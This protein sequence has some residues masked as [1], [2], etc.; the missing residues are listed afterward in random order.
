MTLNKKLV[1]FL[2]STK[3]SIYLKQFLFFD[4]RIMIASF[5]LK[6]TLGFL[7]ECRVC[8]IEKMNFGH[9]LLPTLFVS[10]IILK[11]WPLSHDPL[12][13][14]FKHFIDFVLKPV[15]KGGDEAFQLSKKVCVLEVNFDCNKEK[16]RFFFVLVL[17]V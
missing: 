8:D 14:I 13:V 4:V 10:H 9:P 17:I 1:S 11:Y 2:A 3:L 12:L 6:L 7:R 16:G 5:L 15:L